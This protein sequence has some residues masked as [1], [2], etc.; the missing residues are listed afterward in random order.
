MNYKIIWALCVSMYLAYLPSYIYGQPVNQYLGDVVLPTPN[1]A[2]LG[3]YGDIPVSTYT[4]LPSISVPIYDIS[5]GQVNQSVYLSYHA[6]G[7]KVEEVASRVGLGWTLR[8]GGHVTRIVNGLRDDE[9]NKGYYHEG[10]NLTTLST[11][12]EIALAQGTLDGEPDMF[13]FSCGGYSGQFYFNKDEDVVL[14][15]KQD[16]KISVTLS[17]GDFE[18]FLIITPEGHRHH[19]GKYN[20]TV[21][22]DK[23][24]VT[25]S[26]QPY[27]STWHLLRSETYDRKQALTFEYENSSYSYTS[28]AS[29][30]TYINTCQ[31]PVGLSF[32]IGSI[33]QSTSEFSSGNDKFPY[34]T[35]NIVGERL[36]RIKSDSETITF[37]SN[38]ARTDIGNC[39][40]SGSTTNKNRLDNI[41]VTTGTGTTFCKRFTLAYNYFSDPQNISPSSP[42]SSR[43]KLISVT[44]A[45][46]SGSP[47]K[48]PYEFTYDETEDV[49][50]RHSK[51]RDHWG[52]SNGASNNH[53]TVN[54]P[55]TTVYLPGGDPITHG[56][57]NRDVNEAHLKAGSLTK[58]KYPAG[59]HTE[60]EYEANR[61]TVDGFDETKE[62]DFSNCTT[63]SPAACCGTPDIATQ[64]LVVSGSTLQNVQLYL[65][66]T[67]L[68]FSNPVCGET[69][70]SVTLKITKNGSQI[71]SQG[72]T[73]QFTAN[74]IYHQELYE[75]TDLPTFSPGTYTF[76]LE[77]TDGR[78]DVQLFSRVATRDDELVGGLRVKKMTSHDGIT[79]SRDI[80]RTYEYRLTNNESSGFLL[81]LQNYGAYLEA[82]VVGNGGSTPVDAAIWSSTN[83]IQA[84]SFE[85]N[86]IGYERV[87]ELHNGAGEILYE[88]DIQSYPIDPVPYPVPPIEIRAING[89]IQRKR[90][91]KQG[92]SAAILDEDY[93]RSTNTRY[94][95]S[96]GKMYRVADQLPC[97]SST[98]EDLVFI[99]EYDIPT[100]IYRVGNKTTIRDGVT[101][102]E[103]YTYLSGDTYYAPK[104]KTRTESDGT[105]Y[106]TSYS[107]AHDLSGSVNDNLENLNYVIPIRTTLTVGSN[108]IDGNE[109]IFA[110][111]NG[112]PYPRTYRRY[113]RTWSAGGTIQSGAWVNQAVVNS[114]SSAEGYPTSITTDGWAHPTTYA[115][116]SNGELTSETY[117]QF[118]K[119][120]TYFS[121]SKLLK[122]AINVDQTKTSYTYD[123]LCRVKTIDDDCRN[124]ITTMSYIYGNPASGG[125]Y[126]LES[127]D[128]PSASN[129]ALNIIRTKTFIDGLGR[130]IQIIKEDQGPA[131]NDD[132]VHAF[133]Y[134]NQGRIQYEYEPRKFT[135]N[136][137][138]YKASPNWARTTISYEASPLKRETSRTHSSWN[139][140]IIKSY[141]ANG[142]T[143]NG[144][145]TGTLNRTITTD[146]DGRSFFELFDTR[147]NRVGTV[148]VPSGGSGA[149][150]TLYEYDQKD[151][152]IEIIP[153]G[154]TSGN[155][156]LNTTYVYYRN[157]LVQEKKIAGK[158]KIEYRYNNRDLLIN[159][160]DGHL[161]AQSSLDW[162]AY[163]YDVWGRQTKSGFATSPTGNNSSGNPSITSTNTLSTSTYYSTGATHKDKIQNYDWRVLNP[164]GTLG[165][166]RRT[167]YNYDGCGR[168]SSERSSTLLSS[169]Q[170]DI[171]HNQHSYT[172]D[173]ADN[174]T[175][176][177]HQ[178]TAY[179]STH[180]ADITQTIDFAGRPLLTRHKFDG[181]AQETVARLT[182]TE[183][184]QIATLG[185]GQV[186]G[187]N[188]LQTCT[189]GYKGNRWLETMNSGVFDY[190]LHYNT[191]PNTGGQA[192]KNGN[193]SEATWSVSAGG[194]YAIGYRY[195]GHN[196]ITNSY[197]K[198]LASGGL[199][200]EFATTSSYDA[201]GNFAALTRKGR[202]PGNGYATADYDNLSYTYG[203]GN[204]L[205]KVQ[206][207]ASGGSALGAPGSPNAYV[208]DGNGNVT[209]DPGKGA[210]IQYNHLNLPRKV[211]F[212]HGTI[213]FTYDADGNQLRKKTTSGGVVEDRYYIGDME[214]SEGMLVQVHHPYGR[215]AQRYPCDENQYISGELDDTKTYYGKSIFSDASV[216]PTGISTF[217]GADFVGLQGGFRTE[218][219]KELRVNF[220]NC[221]ASNWQYEYAMQDHLGNTRVVFADV[222]DNGLIS[223]STEILQEM[224]Y[225]PSGLRMDGPW[226]NRSKFDYNYQFNGKELHQD[227]GFDWLAFGARC[228]DGAIGRFM[229]VDPLADE[230]PGWTPYRFAFCNPVNYID[231]DGLFETR[232]AAQEYA[233]EHDIRFGFLGLGRNKIVQQ[234][235]GTYAIQNRKEGSFIQ[236]FGGDIG[237]QKG[238]VISATDVMGSEVNADLTVVS[239]TLR[240]GSTREQS[241]IVGGIAP[242]PGKILKGGKLL[243]ALPA[244]DRTGKVHGVLPKIKDLGR[245][246]KSE[247]KILLK[248]LRQSVQQ[249]IKVTSRKGRDRAHGQRQGA[250]QDLIKSIEKH[251]G[252]RK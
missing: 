74:Y 192:Q 93:T 194:H 102:E 67:P 229:S 107:Y 44:E 1:E 8:A 210:T 10:L 251:L 158:D 26:T 231:P 180:T 98:T 207:S 151:R 11:A 119:S 237:V 111:F 125:N 141:N 221:P 42:A 48:N 92:S 134:D 118:T 65:G 139:F 200:N 62:L 104:T 239:E 191:S 163:N 12:E 27:T 123:Q 4:G 97:G 9:L 46:C 148:S 50:F 64:N 34:H 14:V 71:F 166:T 185:L 150:T 20:S 53:L 224:H 159:Y 41:E 88:Y 43:L 122:D 206:E 130:N 6:G 70:I 55:P 79:A 112:F 228:Y 39:G 103:D 15:P 72:Y 187:S 19:F 99:T 146:Q 250:E 238:A 167:N 120:Y 2:S 113:E 35:I 214:Y 235:D 171:T 32:S 225:Y 189:Y 165:V 7:T 58:I 138:A 203:T 143:F 90:V 109:T 241:L 45:A 101:L 222:N 21:A 87:K 17:S 78:G 29:C 213:E 66:L 215:V 96:V 105:M 232:S 117:N 157:D 212:G 60:F 199:T 121:G 68:E 216:V 196:R 190:T 84:S 204:Q 218:L 77:V 181:L 33:C 30:R 140:P 233:D 246:S 244:L 37:N 175:F 133:V 57:A 94:V 149:L 124:V 197:S 106:Q 160:Q 86:H 75:G 252:N 176:D 188:Y 115:Y 63:P 236:D 162:M 234:S 16:I 135:G 61:H 31:T 24:Y 168:I 205:N 147:G 13:S 152:L 128:Y 136:N 154:S 25:P 245:Y 219:G 156:S 193:I 184:D 28:S 95:N 89:Q 23:V 173:G 116:Q 114:V 177:D 174:I 47:S 144:Y 76:R 38:T 155:A 51:A 220:E 83:L 186:S 145:P 142:S 85:G 240:D 182:Y 217:Q 126:I 198:N 132:V 179:G 226:Q 169:G 69:N 100:E 247:L 52:Y 5:Q 242:S 137:G 227:L 243:E 170:G 108:Q 164:D 183:K 161:R 201:R 22:I 40:V 54:V 209:T 211:T 131:S 153:P 80:E 230:A 91:F 129:S 110:T 202:D 36:R 59:G 56:S 127:M 3:K 81:Y 178:Q 249:R 73:Y 49:P 172:Y 195:D 248:E 18:S 82:R 223:A 208:H